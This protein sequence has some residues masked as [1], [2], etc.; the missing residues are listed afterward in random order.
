MTTNRK[1]RI[2]KF[3]LKSKP[4]RPKRRVF[5]NSISIEDGVSLQDILR[6]IQ[7]AYD[8]HLTPSDVC[9]NKEY[10]GYDDYQEINASWKLDEP[11]EDYQRRLESYKARLSAWN[12]WYKENQEQVESVRADRK[13]AAED[14]AHKR[15]EQERK[16]LRKELAKLER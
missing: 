5:D 4:Q 8:I 11:E 2:S 14:R 16:R 15:I 1:A 6:Q 3:I 7:N 9:I 13:K 12:R 10:N